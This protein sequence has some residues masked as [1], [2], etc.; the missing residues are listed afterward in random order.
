M[1]ETILDLG[2][3]GGSITLLGFRGSDGLRK[4]VLEKNELALRN[5][6]PTEEFEGEAV[7]RSVP[8]TSWDAAVSLLNQNQHWHRLCPKSV[9][10]YFESRILALVQ[11]RGGDSSVDKWRQFCTSEKIY[12]Q[13]ERMAHQPDLGL[14]GTISTENIRILYEKYLALI[15]LETVEFGVKPTEVRHLIG[16][17]GE[18]HCA[19]SIDGSL[20]FTANQHGFDVIS[21]NGR[22]VSVKTTAQKSGFVR[23]SGSTLE[24]VDDL[25]LIQFKDQSL[26]VIYHGPIMTALSVARHYPELGWYELDLS[27]AKEAYRKV[28]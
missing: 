18:F 17:L 28:K 16:R 10:P 23:V 11:E 7:V 20:A 4:F 12:K 21:K 5:M 2:A 6:L 22:R 8:V 25:M 1:Q 15:R 19:L 26:L 14:V 13:E 27:R 3:E 24:K 9:H